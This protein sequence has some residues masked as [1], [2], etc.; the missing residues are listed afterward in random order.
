MFIFVSHPSWYTIYKFYCLGFVSIFNNIL[1]ILLKE[2]RLSRE[3]HYLLQVTDRLDMLLLS[4]IFPGENHRPW[5]SNWQ[6]RHAHLT[7]LSTIFQSYWWR[8]P[9]YQEKIIDLHLV[10]DR[11]VLLQALWFL[12]NYDCELYKLWQ[13]NPITCI[14]AYWNETQIVI[15]IKITVHFSLELPFILCD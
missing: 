15:R 5:S 6:T 3:N 8:K 1:V 14:D 7:L 2:T 10:T 13:I 9:D 12:I 11:P 4:V